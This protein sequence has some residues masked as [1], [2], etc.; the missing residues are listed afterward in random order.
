MLAL[1]HNAASTCSQKVR[2]ILAEKK[3]E[4]ESRDVDL[5]GGG[6][7]DPE[8][9]KLNPNHVVPTLVH[10]E[11][12]FIESTLINEYLD[13]AFPQIAMKPAD[14]AGRHA[15]RLWTRRIDEL[16]PSAGV[17]TYAIGT[18]PMILQRAQADIDAH[19]EQ[20][21]DPQ[22]R[23]QRRS[24]IEKGIDAPEFGGAMRSWSFRR[25]SP[26]ARGVRGRDL[27]A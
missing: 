7:H 3:L 13:D 12:V 19:V 6:Q 23:A 4:W 27:A 24:V 8:Y 1:Y 11:G 25:R 5:V 14:P 16:H 20:I 9:T 17:L 10:D 26:R 2:L 21:P 15:M 18:R 22:R